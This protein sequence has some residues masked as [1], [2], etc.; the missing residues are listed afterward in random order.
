[1]TLNNHPILQFKF[2]SLCDSITGTKESGISLILSSATMFVTRDLAWIE[3]LATFA[4][5]PEGVFEDVVPSEVTRVHLQLFDTS[6]HVKA[7][8]MTGAVV[9][10]LGNVDVK[11][12]L[13]SDSD[14]NT[15]SV[16]LSTLNMLVVDDIAF[17]AQLSPGQ[18]SS[19][20]AWRL[21]GY[22]P[23]VEVATTEVV[24]WRDT[25]GSDEIA[26]DI[27]GCQVKVTACADSLAL[28]G[29]LLGDLATIIPSA[30]ADTVSETKVKS[31]TRLDRSINVFDS[32]DED[33]FKKVIPEMISGAD[34]IEDDLP[35][36]L[37]YLD[38]TTSR[39][40]T[41]KRVEGES[42]RSWQATSAEGEEEVGGE[43]I[44][45]LYEGELCLEEN[46]WENLPV[47]TKGDSNG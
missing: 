14:E 11:T 30:K 22:V 16:S 10:V 1:L 20:N 29:P 41:S 28:L 35:T 33:A 36:N 25:S 46:Y 12:D 2:T 17:T 26:V 23:L 40:S 37:D 32:I 31:P 19:V 44:K 24:V 39:K 43:T 45:V 8:N 27:D 15:L 6:A 13:I 34:L 3:E 4:K 18:G 5:T 38:T 42:L 21:S 47:V 9:L 7:P